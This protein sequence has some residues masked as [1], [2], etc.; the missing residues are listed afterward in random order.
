MAV[1]SYTKDPDAVL[2]YELDWSEWLDTDTIASSSWTADTGITI[3][4]DTNTTT[5]A[6]VW[7]S[8]GTVGERYEVTNHI[9]TTAGREDDRS[10]KIKCKEK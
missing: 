7:V 6:T 4:S 10:I 2:D 5:T 8:G 3:D 9:V 1:A